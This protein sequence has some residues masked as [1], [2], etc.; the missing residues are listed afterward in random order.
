MQFPLFFPLPPQPGKEATQRGLSPL[1]E[2]LLPARSLWRYWD[3]GRLPA[4]AAAGWAL[5][6]WDA[7]EWP[8]GAGVLGCVRARARVCVCVSVCV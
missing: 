1:A 8:E 4:A 7:S 2:V 3:R 5:P 6:E